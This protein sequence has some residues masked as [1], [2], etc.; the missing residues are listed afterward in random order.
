MAVVKQRPQEQE[1]GQPAVPAALAV[2]AV[3]AEAAAPSVQLGAGEPAPTSAAAGWE[4]I[5]LSSQELVQEEGQAGPGDEWQAAASDYHAASEKF[6]R[7][8][9]Q[10]LASGDA[11]TDGRPP[12]G[13]GSGGT[14][15]WSDK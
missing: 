13:S 3:A 12:F 14:V 10:P 4:G 9:G 11:P 6:I 8:P 15:D 5:S 7:K 2:A 1:G